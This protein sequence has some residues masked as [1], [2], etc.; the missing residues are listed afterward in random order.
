LLS[1]VTFLG[2]FSRGFTLGLTSLV[3]FNTFC[4]NFT[5]SFE[6]LNLIDQVQALQFVAR[7]EAVPLGIGADT[8]F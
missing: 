2:L 8:A 3:F 4:Q 5:R 7:F 1:L 6:C